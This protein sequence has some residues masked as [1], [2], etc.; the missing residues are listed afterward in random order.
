M[1]GGHL[2]FLKF[3]EPRVSLFSHI[4]TGLS[5]TSGAA[6]APSELVWVMGQQLWCQDHLQ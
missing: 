3:G 2:C 4:C 1:R 6:A 5:L